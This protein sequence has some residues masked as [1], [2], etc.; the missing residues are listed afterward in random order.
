MV[1]KFLQYF[2]LMT[3]ILFGFF[4]SDKRDEPVKLSLTEL[5]DSSDAV[6]LVRLESSEVSRR[7]SELSWKY[8]N[9]VQLKLE[10]LLSL[11]GDLRTGDIFELTIYQP[12]GK[13]MLGNFGSYIAVELTDTKT[14]HLLFLKQKDK[15]WIPTS[16]YY[17]AGN[18][19][20]VSQCSG[21]F[22][23]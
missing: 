20:F 17:D 6:V 3:A 18:S 15:R 9:E 11:K 2:V 8:F 19:H 16:G 7:Y 1:E 21:F 10:V 13:G 12:N 14:P 4:S 22:R 23:P 5:Q